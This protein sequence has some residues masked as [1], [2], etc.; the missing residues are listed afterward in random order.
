MITI[1]DNPDI[2]KMLK[3]S[4]FDYFIVDCEHGSMDY[5]KVAGLFGM[6]RAIGIPGLVRI[7][8]VKREVVLK[9]MEAGAEGILLPNTET[10][11]QAKALVEYSKYAPMGN[12]GVS[13][14]RAHSGYENVGNAVEYMKITNE[15][16]IL[17][18]QIESTTGVENIGDLLDVEGIDAAFIGPSDL[19]Q[20][21]GIMGQLEHTV[22][23]SALEK[24]ISAA[25]ER[26]KFAGI[27]IMYGKT[28]LLPKW[29]DKGM[30][31]NLWTNDVEML[32]NSGKQGLEKIKSSY[33][34]K[35]IEV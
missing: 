22:F 24:V 17:M 19:S 33:V 20:S 32:M 15:E 1:F 27:H 26:S 7:P 14:L 28:P 12:R 9:Y 23:V 34:V 18:I 2:V 16:T 10:V 35:G 3:V 31:L 5:S 21:M 25:K 13:L 6:A 29:I 11:E 8:E 30:T 4:G